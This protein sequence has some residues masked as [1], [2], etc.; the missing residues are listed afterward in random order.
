MFSAAFSTHARAYVEV[1]AQRLVDQRTALLVR[2]EQ[3]LRLARVVLQEDVV[4]LRR[5]LDYLRLYVS[6]RR[7]LQLLRRQV[8]CLLRRGHA[9]SRLP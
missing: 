1:V 4:V 9:A 5:D 8:F 7:L 6:R 3:H 2:E